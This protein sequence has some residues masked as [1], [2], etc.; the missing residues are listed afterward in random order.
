MSTLANSEDPDEIPH[1][2]D[3]VGL[4]KNLDKNDLLQNKKYIFLGNC[5]L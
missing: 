1:R 5:S 3:T 2:V 4:D